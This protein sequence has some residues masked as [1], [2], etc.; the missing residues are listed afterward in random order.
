MRITPSVGTIGLYELR[1]PWKVA[2]GEVYECIANRAM[3]DFLETG[4]DVFKLVYE[5]VKLSET[6]YAEDVKEEACI[7]SL[8][9]RT[10][11]TAPVIHIP[12]TRIVS[13]PNMDISNY[14]RMIV[15][16]DL[17]ALP[18]NT[19][20][21]AML[22]YLKQAAIDM[23]GVESNPVVHKGP[24]TNTITFAEHE[25][26]LKKRIAHKKKNHSLQV[27]NEKLIAENVE[28]RR[29]LDE[30]IRIIQKNI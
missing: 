13:Y 18:I 4:T 23:V 2:D 27:I 16:V 21:S 26:L 9:N 20:V 8:L 30:A 7:I 24:S 25:E 3:S 28:L 6:D 22:V 5:P 10:D 11:S 14:N 17:G 15:S 29:Q 12:D 19:D 1:E